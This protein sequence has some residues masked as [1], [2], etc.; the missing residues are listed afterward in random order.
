MKYRKIQNAFIFLLL[1]FYCNNF[2]HTNTESYK[3]IKVIDGDTVYIDFNNNGIA[4]SDERVRINGIDTF[5]TK[6]SVYLDW[7][8]KKYNLTK[9]ESLGLGYLGKEFA[10]KELLN[11]Y[12]IAKYTSD[13]KFDANKR[14]LMSIYYNKNKNYEQEILK[15]GLAVIYEKSNIA[16]ELRAYENIEKIKANKQK[17]YSLVLLNLRNNKYHKLDCQYGQNTQNYTIVDIK[18]LKKH[19]KPA[20]CCYQ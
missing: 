19:M 3:V 16:E 2:C 7:Q 8:M 1:L 14:H 4:D 6:P 5:E 18:K 17:T 11:K 10:K 20:K 15:A 12:I 9:E 13:R